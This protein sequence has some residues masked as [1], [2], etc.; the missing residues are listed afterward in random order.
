LGV[1]LEIPIG[2]HVRIKKP[3]WSIKEEFGEV[4]KHYPEEAKY[5]VRTPDQA[6]TANWILLPED[7]E[8]VV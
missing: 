4:T 8:V 7:V 3:R 6:P 1:K 2:T 5:G